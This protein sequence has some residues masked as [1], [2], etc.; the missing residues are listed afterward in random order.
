MIAALEDK[1]EGLR[2]AILRIGRQHPANNAV[3]SLQSVEQPDA[4]HRVTSLL[5]VRDRELRS[6]DPRRS[7]NTLYVLR[8]YQVQRFLQQEL[9][10]DSRTA[11][12]R[13]E[14]LAR[15]FREQAV[16][17]VKGGRKIRAWARQ[18]LDTGTIPR[19]EQGRHAKIESLIDQEDVMGKCFEW[20]RLQRKGTLT[21]EAFLKFLNLELLP[22]LHWYEA[23]G[24]ALS[25]S[26]VSDARVLDD[27]HSEESD[28]DREQVV[29]VVVLFSLL[30]LHRLCFVILCRY[31]RWPRVS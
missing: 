5:D 18:F 17:G 16:G 26:V 1:V 7:S 22:T 27:D 28:G 4:S 12:E 9:E 8:L 15:S 10:S 6:G 25:E 19:A 23:P 14:A 2:K 30:P 13:S 29:H 3:V 31:P 24:E 11:I 20:C 21:S